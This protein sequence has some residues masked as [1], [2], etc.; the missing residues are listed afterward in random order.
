MDRR[1]TLLNHNLEPVLTLYILSDLYPQG[2]RELG[3]CGDTS[4]KRSWYS[5]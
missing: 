1:G 2:E 5:P 4:G 3:V